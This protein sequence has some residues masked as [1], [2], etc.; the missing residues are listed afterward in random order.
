MWRYIRK[1]I[2]RY[3]S[4]RRYIQHERKLARRWRLPKKLRLIQSWDELQDILNDA[5]P[6]QFVGGDEMFIV[7]L[8]PAPHYL[9]IYG[10]DH[11]FC[12]TLDEAIQ[13][14]DTPLANKPYWWA[15]PHDKETMELVQEILFW[16]DEY[17]KDVM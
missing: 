7:P 11:K 15:I 1:R 8:Y 6:I 12:W 16:F 9:A 14:M 10:E 3:K 5:R 13:F 4:H 17:D 2:K